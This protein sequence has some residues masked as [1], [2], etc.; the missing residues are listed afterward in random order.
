VGGLGTRLYLDLANG[1][2]E[3]VEI[4]A[5]GWRVIDDPPVRFPRAAGM[6]PLPVPVRGG[7]IEALRPFLNV[8]TASQPRLALRSGSSTAAGGSE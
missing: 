2:W 3:A 4:D 5:T 8:R 6:Q 7:S 1:T